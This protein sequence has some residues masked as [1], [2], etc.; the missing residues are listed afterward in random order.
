MENHYR[1]H[2]NKQPYR[3][4]II[5]GHA[6]IWN[7]LEGKDARCPEMFRMERHTFL[8]LCDC[9]RRKNLLKGTCHILVVKQLAIFMKTI[10]LR[11]TNRDIADRFQHSPETIS[12]HFSNVLKAL[13]LFFKEVVTPPDFQNSHPYI[14]CNDKYF[15]WFENSVGEIDGT[16]ISAW[17]PADKQIPYRGR[18]SETT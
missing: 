10:G 13:C 7:V 3:D 9:F 18:K 2:L 1:L 16:H 12:R 14:R 11:E 8:A 4:D 15:P 6:Y 17:L 5:R